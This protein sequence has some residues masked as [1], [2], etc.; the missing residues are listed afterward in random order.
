M[1]R[2]IWSVSKQSTGWSI[3][4]RMAVEIYMSGIEFPINARQ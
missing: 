1:N 4:F 3:L 2:I